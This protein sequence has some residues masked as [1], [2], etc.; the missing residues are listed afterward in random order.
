MRA[1]AA[2]QPAPRRPALGG[3][4]TMKEIEREHFERVL[5]RTRS[6]EE[7]ARILG[8]DV[9]TVWRTKKRHDTG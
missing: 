8:I 6:Q 1:A 2:T 5:A 3:D 4:H 9:T 7:A